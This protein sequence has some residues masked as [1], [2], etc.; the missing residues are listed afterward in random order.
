MRILIT[1]DF[2]LRSEVALIAVFSDNIDII[3]CLTDVVCFDDVFVFK[4]PQSL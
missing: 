4:L 2:D 3:V 1:F